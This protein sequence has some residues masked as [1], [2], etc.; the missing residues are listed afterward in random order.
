MEHIIAET[1][2]D[3]IEDIE[4]IDRMGGLVPC[5]ENGIIQKEIAI[6]AYRHQQRIE[7]RQVHAAIGFQVYRASRGQRHRSGDREM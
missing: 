1:L 6:E 5:I 3:R 7:H 2:A 4:R